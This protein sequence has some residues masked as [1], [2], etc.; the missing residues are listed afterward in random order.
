VRTS[1]ALDTLWVPVAAMLA[2][3]SAAAT[4]GWA[5][6]RAPLTPTSPVIHAADIEPD[7]TDSEAGAGMADITY[8]LLGVLDRFRGNK[9]APGV[10][11]TIAVEPNLATCVD[12]GPFRRALSE[13]IGTAA[14]RA[15]G[16]RVL[17]SVAPEHDGWVQV[18]VADGGAA[19]DRAA[20]ERSVQHAAQLIRQQGGAFSLDLHNGQGTTATMRLPGRT[21]H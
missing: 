20:V 15:P 2:V 12:P 21:R 5:R 7:D 14:N 3:A 6:R 8:E 17:V 18:C 19:S 9:T 1:A 10:R 13:L 16:S 4:A 11:F